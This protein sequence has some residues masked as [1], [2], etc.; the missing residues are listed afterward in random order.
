MRQVFVVCDVSFVNGIIIQKC[1]EVRTLHTLF[2]SQWFGVS[3]SNLAVNY[4]TFGSKHQKLVGNPA[5][6]TS[7]QLNSFNLNW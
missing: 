4:V 3:D 7:Y 2:G 1:S 5:H 6:Q